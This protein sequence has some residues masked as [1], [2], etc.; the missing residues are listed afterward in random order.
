[1]IGVVTDGG[2]VSTAHHQL[3]QASRARVEAD[4]L[5]ERL[6]AATQHADRTT[7]RVQ[8]TRDRLADAT[9]DVEKLES[10]SFSRILSTLKGGHATDVE[11]E[12][13][14]RD[15][16]RYAVADAEARDEVAWRDVEGLQAQLD[17]LGDVDAAYDAALAAKEE[18]AASH[19]PEVAKG[20]AEIAER[21][22]VVLAED[23]EA[24]EAHAAGAAARDLLT[25]AEQLL[26]GARSWSTWDTFGGGGM[27]TDM[28]KYDKLD[29]VAEVLRRADI[30]LG[31]FTREL[32][33]LHLAGVRGVEIDGM[34]R[35]FDMFFDNIFTDLQVRSRIQDAEGRVG[36]ALRAV[37]E[38]LV[39]LGERGR[40][41]ADEL[42]ELDRRREELLAR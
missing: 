29:Q 34:T 15:A 19:D 1:M 23:H 28:M 33:D 26:S 6:E 42:A 17:E 38:T 16:A 5:R 35:T 3:E 9:E 18:W 7:L 8:E 14:E 32:A 4:G 20:L 36:A 12:T 40:T 31:A 2:A 11:R 22:G 27:L 39:Q 41:Y 24:R 25:H 37:T 13:A 21:R 30:A 10:F